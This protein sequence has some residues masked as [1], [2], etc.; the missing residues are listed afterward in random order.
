LVSRGAARR[1]AERVTGRGSRVELP[2]VGT[3]TLPPSDQ[4]AFVGGVAALVALGL[5]DWPV[6][7][8]LGVGHLLAAGRSNRM[9]AEF[10][11]ALEEV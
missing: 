6:G 10:G 8:L 7:V 3:V 11:E 5:V 1:A 9:L 2:V 4:L